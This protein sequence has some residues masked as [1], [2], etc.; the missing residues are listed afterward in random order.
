MFLLSRS[1]FVRFFTLFKDKAQCTLVGDHFH[2]DD[3]AAH[4]DAAVQLAASGAEPVEP[5]GY[6]DEDYRVAALLV[7]CDSTVV[8]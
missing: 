4:F 2:L 6:D 7:H 3:R 8:N 5:V 1:N